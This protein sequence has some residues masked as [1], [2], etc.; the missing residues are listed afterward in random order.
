MKL[1]NG[2]NRSS[3]ECSPESRKNSPNQENNTQN[4]VDSCKFTRIF[5]LDCRFDIA[6]SADIVGGAREP[7]GIE[8]SLHEGVLLVPALA[9][10]LIELGGILEWDIVDTPSS[11]IKV[12]GLRRASLEV[13]A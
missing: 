10:P 2:P 7:S 3:H 9:K 8:I 12:D 5:C 4:N 13:S 6:F 1:G 11:P